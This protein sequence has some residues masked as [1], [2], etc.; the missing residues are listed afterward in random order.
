MGFFF[1]QNASR[2]TSLGNRR[3]AMIDNLIPRAFP[4][5]SKK[6]FIRFHMTQD[7]G[8]RGAR[9]EA[10]GRLVASLGFP[11]KKWKRSSGE[12]DG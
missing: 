7:E 8:R 4:R 2:E 10:R 11:L 3:E 12:K 5:L 6:K 9:R 1:N